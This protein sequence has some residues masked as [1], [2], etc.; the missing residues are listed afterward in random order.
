M[1]SLKEMQRPGL[2]VEGAQESPTGEKP[3][4]TPAVFK[5][6]LAQTGT[7]FALF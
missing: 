2:I 4:D 3:R 1:Q 5:A 6:V 7:Q